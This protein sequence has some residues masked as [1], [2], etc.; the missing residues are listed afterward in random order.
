MATIIAPTYVA[1][2]LPTS[3]PVPDQNY[4]DR[5]PAWKVLIAE[6]IG[7][8][9]LVFIGALTAAQG[10]PNLAIGF[11]FGLVLI[12]MIYIFGTYSGAHFNPAITFG[13]F[14]AGQMSFWAMLLYWIVQLLASIAAAALI[15]YF[16]GTA[17]GVGATVGSLTYSQPWNA[18]FLE[19]VITFVLV[20]TVLILV[21]NPM[22][23]LI[24]G[25]TIGLVL[26]ALNFAFIP[27]TGASMN[28][29]RSLGPAAFSGNLSSIWI[30]ILGPLLGAF[31]AA[32]VY[33]LF[34]KMRSECDS[35][36]A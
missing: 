35:C 9:A 23:A 12:A 17:G 18:F 2:G 8:F 13:F 15:V 3:L 33:L 5:L 14:V 6:F 27:L 22:L 28:P 11:A 26:A 24:A 19:V 1:S 4:T 31:I 32:L 36:M 16:V 21:N 29:A 7:T 10:E 20:I 30:Y 34:T 25:L